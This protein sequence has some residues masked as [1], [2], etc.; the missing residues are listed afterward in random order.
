MI[1]LGLEFK[2]DVPFRTVYI[3]GLVRDAQGRKMSK[4]LGNSIDP[5]EMI[6][7]YGADALRFTFASHLYSGKDMKFSEQRLEGYRNFMNKIW[8]AARFALTNLSDF[9]APAEGVKALPNKA[10]I[11]V[12]DQWIITKLAEVTKEVEEA[13]ESE[14]FSDAA[15]ALYHFI[16]NQ[17]CDLVY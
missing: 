9:Q 7:K 3:H 15:N 2:R 6:E 16:W 5:V 10:D 11:S 14:G 4:S 17:F 12:F 8:N 13:M 1:M